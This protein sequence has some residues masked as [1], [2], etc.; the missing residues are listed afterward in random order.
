ME[1]SNKGQKVSSQWL[2]INALKI[3]NVKKLDNQAKWVTTSF[4]ASC[5]W[6]IRFIKQKKINF[7]KRDC[8]KERTAEECIG[9]FEEFLNK[10]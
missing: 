9:D 5:G 7:R 1:K 6:M 2:R 8:D 10:V 3:F 4:K